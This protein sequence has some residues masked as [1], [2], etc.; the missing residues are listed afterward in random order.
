MPCS[1][2]GVPL[3][4]LFALLLLSTSGCGYFMKGPP[5][6][7]QNMTSF[8]CDQSNALP[9]LDAV[10]AGLNLAGALRA[11][12]ESEPGYNEESPETVVIV[13]LGWGLVSG[14]AAVT[15]F[16]KV[17]R[18]N[19]AKRMLAQR[20]VDASAVRSA[21]IAG[22]EIIRTVSI[23]PRADTISVG[24]RLQLS[25]IAYADG[26]IK[27]PN[28]QFQWWSSNPEIASVDPQGL[29]TA[30]APGVSTVGA[31]AGMVAGGA[32]LLVVAAP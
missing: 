25:A 2:R 29:V 19:E 3:A 6:G 5:V 21:S 31:I 23:S 22:W 20:V 27:L 12:A 9:I 28:A 26:A 14:M 15:G 17:K 30:H 13:G 18:C 11:A 8:T 16:G 32:R 10:W 24:D 4:H 1:K 7:H